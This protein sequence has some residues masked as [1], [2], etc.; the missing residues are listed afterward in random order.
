VPEDVHVVFNEPAFRREFQSWEGDVGQWLSS[1]T[2]SLE[3]LA[4]GSAGVDTGRLIAEIRTA[5]DQTTGGDLEARVGANPDVD[6]GIGYGYWNHEGTFPH[7][8]RPRRPG[9]V[10]RFRSRGM[11][12]YA[13]KVNHPGTKATK[14]LTKWL[15]ELF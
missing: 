8:I 9:G 13:T 3:V 6:L 11:V 1:K 7:E 15:G 5:R 12:V 14:Y 2:E 4:K 10:L